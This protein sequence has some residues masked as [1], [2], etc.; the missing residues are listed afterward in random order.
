MNSVSS[1]Q[2]MMNMVM[3]IDSLLEKNCTLMKDFL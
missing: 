2:E 3:H 1:L